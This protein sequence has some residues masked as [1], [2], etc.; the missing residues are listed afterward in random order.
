VKNKVDELKLRSLTWD[1][2]GISRERYRELQHFC[3]QYSEKKKKAADATDYGSM[4]GFFT[5]DRVGGKSSGPS[6]P[7]ESAV[8]RGIM[9]QEK[10]LKDVKMID[11]AAAW[12]ASIGGYSKAWNII[13]W[14][15]TR[16]V[17]Y[18]KLLARYEFVPWSLPDFYAVRRAFFAR[19]DDLQN[20][21]SAKKS[22]PGVPE[23]E[24]KV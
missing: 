24:K 18:D 15:V 9:L 16:G 12:A 23:N 7:I 10:Y 2:Y 6:N 22:P 5:Y 19:L 14:S 17:G 13:L 8:I 1:D 21:A 20:E 4:T 3:R 11:E